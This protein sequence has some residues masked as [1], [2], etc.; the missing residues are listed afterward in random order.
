LDRLVNPSARFIGN[1][2]AVTQP[3]A[4]FR[5]IVPH[6]N[7]LVVYVPTFTVSF[8][9]GA[10]EIPV[11]PQDV[12]GGDRATRPNDPTGTPA[13]YGTPP[14]EG[15]WLMMQTFYGWLREGETQAW[16]FATPITS[17]MT[18]TAHWAA[19][20]EPVDLALTGTTLVQAAVNHVSANAT[21]GAFTLAI[22]Q[23]YVN[24]GPNTLDALHANLTIIG[25]GDVAREIRLI[26]SAGNQGVRLFDVGP[27]TV[28][29]N[30]N[31]ARLTL[32]NNITLV[33]RTH[34]VH[35]QGYNTS[36]FVRV[37]NG[38]R[39]FMEEGSKITGNTNI[40]TQAGAGRG[41]AVVVGINGIFTMRGGTITGNRGSHP[42]TDFASGVSLQSL[43]GR[44]YMEG[45]SVIGNTRGFYTPV[46]ADI[47]IVNTADY[48]TVSETATI[49]RLIL[50]SSSDTTV[51][52]TIGTGWTGRV[53]DLDLRFNSEEIAD[54]IDTLT[55]RT[56]LRAASNAAA[57]AALG[58]IGY[59]SARFI[60]DRVTVTQDI[61]DYHEIA[62]VGND[63]VV[64][65]LP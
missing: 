53:Y 49:G 9:S 2:A 26:T 63:G 59:T 58:S 35:G 6:G 36:D 24:S 12:R 48:F 23:P 46:Y 38:G 50:D 19:P 21:A 57:T 52:I 44:F 13:W 55:G 62:I 29:N 65:A 20:T 1:T 40:T 17:D 47:T 32:G 7:A 11:A 61:A 15:L 4:E 18:L 41:A 30:V 31:A 33:G 60:G 51:P 22:D 28:S 37:R 8:D 3:I 42:A 25:L 54:V 5:R 56:I 64:R 14:S 45:G 10:G 16:D 39:L 27:G 34:N 43:S